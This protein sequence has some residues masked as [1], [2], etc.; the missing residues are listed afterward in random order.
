MYVIEATITA[1]TISAASLDNG[2]HYLPADRCHWEQEAVAGSSD[3]RI[4]NVHFI[5][6]NQA[7]DSLVATGNSFKLGVI[8]KSGRFVGFTV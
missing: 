8:G 7:P 2:V 6:G 5:A 3:Y 1:G 4:T